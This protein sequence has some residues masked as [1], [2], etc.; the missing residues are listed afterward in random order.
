M[1]TQNKKEEIIIKGK[2]T[3]GYEDS[4]EVNVSE[5]SGKQLAKFTIYTK[6]G[7]EVK[8]INC[9]AWDNNIPKVDKLV[10]DDLVEIKGYYGKEYKTLKGNVKQ[11]FI[12]KECTKLN[13]SIKGN[14]GQGYGNNPEIVISDVNGKQVANFSVA[15]NETNDK[16]EAKWYNCQAWGEKIRIV[17]NFKK[18]DFVELNGI[19]GKE[20]KTNKNE[21][22]KD[23][24]DGT[25]TIQL[26]DMLSKGIYYLNVESQTFNKIIKINKQ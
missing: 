19:F 15:I 5:L 8:Y 21:L 6:S 1:E 11:D 7:E 9:V 4:P 12:V 2:V 25:L 26:P 13:T 3:P 16:S 24:V 17:E 10:K 14:I 23:F 22:K 20:Y 18:G